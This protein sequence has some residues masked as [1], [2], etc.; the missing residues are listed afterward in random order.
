MDMEH[1]MDLVWELILIPALGVLGV[2]I[3]N[4]IKAKTEK[5][6]AEVNNEQI[7]KYISLAENAISK[8]VI[9]VNQTYV[10]TLK[11]QG[12]FDEEAQIH[13]FES[14]KEMALAMMTEEVKVIVSHAVADFDTWVDTT[15]E[16]MVSANK[17]VIVEEGAFYGA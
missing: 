6:K 5:L 12:C 7:N 1:V 9:A 15:I 16:N 3:V 4:F 2:Y 14:A 11:K 17:I 13:A 8:A 10:E